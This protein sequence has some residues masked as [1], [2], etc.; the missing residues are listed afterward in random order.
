MYDLFEGF[1]SGYAPANLTSV[2]P[3]RLSEQLWT[4]GGVV[5]VQQTAKIIN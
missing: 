1:A 4:G 3:F 5:G 2:Q